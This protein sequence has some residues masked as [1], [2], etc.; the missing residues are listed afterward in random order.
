MGCPA[1]SDDGGSPPA[2][3]GPGVR[4]NRT[5]LRVTEG[6]AASISYNVRLN[7][8]PGAATSVAAYTQLSVTGVTLSSDN[9]TFVPGST[10][11]TLNFTPGSSGNWNTNQTVYVKVA[12]DNN[13]DARNIELIHEFAGR[14]AREARLWLRAVESANDCE[15][16]ELT[17]DLDFD[18]N[19][20]GSVTSADAALA[21]GA[22]AGWTPIGDVSNAYDAVFRGHGH[23]I[24]NLF[25]N[26]S[27][28]ANVG[29]F[30]AIGDTM[31]ASPAWACPTPV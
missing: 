20:D 17:S 12:A 31:P 15:G 30:G 11:L 10:G 2:V 28:V 22:G 4:L 25:I 14:I 23:T 27:G 13:S 19:D 24:S 21:W 5:T 7:A 29:L 16:Y 26:S 8:D 9:S 6:A 18:T 1:Y 3:S